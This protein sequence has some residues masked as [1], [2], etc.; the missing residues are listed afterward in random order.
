MPPVPTPGKAVLKPA[1][2]A[3]DSALKA[4]GRL[5]QI[6]QGEQK[7]KADDG[8]DQDNGDND[9]DGDNQDGDDDEKNGKGHRKQKDGNTGDDNGDDE[10]DD[11]DN[12]DDEDDFEIENIVFDEKTVGL[13]KSFPYDPQVCGAQ[14]VCYACKDWVPE[15]HCH[16]RRRHCHSRHHRDR[17]CGCR[18]HSSHR[19]YGSDHEG[20]GDEGDMKKVASQLQMLRQVV[21]LDADGK[22]IH[23]L[24]P[25]QDQQLSIQVDDL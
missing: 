10:D 3:K 7:K 2:S 11:G 18:R 25:Q 22:I 9:D 12:Q 8:D 5:L 19:L 20:S 21:S 6:P 17:H 4:L 16:R 13:E 24:D 1:D 15:R 14:C 23:E